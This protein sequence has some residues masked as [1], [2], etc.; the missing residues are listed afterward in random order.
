LLG[1]NLFAYCKN[2]PIA[3]ADPVGGWS[4]SALITTAIAT[5]AAIAVAVIAA[6]KVKSRSNSV[7]KGVENFGVDSATASNIS[8]YIANASEYTYESNKDVGHRD[9]AP[10]TVDCAY[11]MHF[12]IGGKKGATKR[13]NDI[14]KK[15]KGEIDF[16]DISNLKPG[17]EVFQLK[18]DKNGN[19]VMDDN[20]Q[21]QMSHVGLLVMYDFGTG[22]ELAVFHSVAVELTEDKWKAIFYGDTGPNI[23]SLTRLDG[24]SNWTHYGTH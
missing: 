11:L 3:S 8:G 17:M 2:E 19:V 20:G 7:S 18:Y 5:A 24:T 10:K 9:S 12:V 23:T 6:V 21:P 15:S 4:I 1:R 14:S 13:Y 22:S 16:D